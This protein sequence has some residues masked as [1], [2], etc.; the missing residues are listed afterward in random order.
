MSSIICFDIRNFSTHVSH[1]SL[2]GK[3]DIIFDLVVNIFKSL[4]K[5]IK[6]S[7]AF[8]EISRETFINH[9]GDG[10]L[11]IFYGKDKS[12]QSLYAASLIS[13]DVQ[14]LLKKYEEMVNSETKL[15]LVPALDFGIGIHLGSVKKFEYNPKYPGN[16]RI[17]G[18]LGDSINI[19]YRVQESTKDHIFKVI[20]TRRL[21]GDAIKLIKDKHKKTFINYFTKLEKHKLR[22]MRG[23]Y[24]LYGV[25]QNFAMKIKPN[26]IQK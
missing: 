1:L 2:E 5:A 16:Q 14:N 22:G 13:N 25:K 9:T 18:F 12:L 10:F 26:M 8:F 23:P 7:R 3:T 24:T 19:S 11:A 20:C 17:L 6:K 21:Y 15:K 4:E